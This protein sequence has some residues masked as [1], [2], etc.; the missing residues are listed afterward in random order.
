MPATATTN[1]IHVSSLS[2]EERVNSVKRRLLLARATC[3]MEPDETGVSRSDLLDA[4]AESIEDMLELLE[5]IIQAR[6]SVLNWVPPTS[7]KAV[8]RLKAL[9][10]ADG[11]R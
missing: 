3:G 1:H 4:I 2:L 10:A 8:D 11:A 7:A 9:T 5:P 6:S